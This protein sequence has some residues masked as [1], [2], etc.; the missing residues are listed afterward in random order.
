MQTNV[1]Q[2]ILTQEENLTQATRQ[3]D[4]ETLGRLYAD[5][6]MFTGVTG[7]VC[8]KSALMAE[9]RRGAAEREGAAQG[10]AAVMS[11]DK[12]DIRIVTH[13]GAAVTSYRFVIRLQMDGKDIQRRY[14]TTNV[15]I[16]RQDRWQ[17]AA[18]HTADLK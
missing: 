9:A 14:R 2:E 12:E 13:A 6:I 10:K 15:W 5:D 11:Y 18:A 17:V 8:D 7:D 16:R 1:E 4:I 3:L